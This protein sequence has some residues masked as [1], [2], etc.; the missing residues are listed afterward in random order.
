MKR[1]EVLAALK[2][3]MSQND[4][5]RDKIVDFFQN[6]LIGL[7][8]LANETFEVAS[9]VIDFTGKKLL[10]DSHKLLDD[11]Q[12][13]HDLKK[14]TYQELLNEYTLIDLAEKK[15]VTTETLKVFEYDISQLLKIYNV[16]AQVKVE[17]IMLNELDKEFNRLPEL[18]KLVNITFKDIVY[19]WETLPDDY[20][21]TYEP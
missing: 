20:I 14:E 18:K 13:Y 5:F 6:Y 17:D 15:R 19:F 2:K 21:L 9:S 7:D 1:T 11:F 16:R 8:N 3:I 4:S 10:N 12:K